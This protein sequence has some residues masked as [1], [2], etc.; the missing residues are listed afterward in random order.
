MQHKAST[1]SESSSKSMPVRIQPVLYGRIKVHA[2]VQ[3]TSI[4]A[5]VNETLEAAISD[6][7]ERSVAGVVELSQGI[8]EESCPAASLDGRLEDPMAL[9]AS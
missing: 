8:Q 7:F 9:R 6:E 1:V 2:A 5:W 4:Q 3:G